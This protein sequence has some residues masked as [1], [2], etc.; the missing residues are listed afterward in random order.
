MASKKYYHPHKKFLPTPLEDLLLG[1]LRRIGG[2]AVLFVSGVLWLSLLTWSATDPSL[3]VISSQPPSNA[4]GPLGA[5]LADLLLNTI[6]LSAV[7]VL[8]CC[9][10]WGLQLLLSERVEGFQVRVFFAAVAL[11]GIAGGSSALPT[12][13]GWLFHHGYGGIIGDVILNLFVGLLA[14]FQVSFANTLSGLSLFAFGFWAFSRAIG[15]DRKHIFLIIRPQ[16]RPRNV[17]Q[18]EPVHAEEPSWTKS[19]FGAATSAMWASQGSAASET[20]AQ[21]ATVAED[22]EPPSLSPIAQPKAE[23]N[24][25]RQPAPVRQEDDSIMGLKS[26]LEA[27]VEEA[28]VDHDAKRIAQIFA[29]E[30]SEQVKQPVQPELPLQQAPQPSPR[31]DRDLPSFLLNEREDEVEFFVEEEIALAEDYQQPS[32]EELNEPEPVSVEP[33]NAV[34]E[35]RAT[36]AKLKRVLADFRITGDIAD[37]KKGPMITLFEFVPSAGIKASRVVALADDIARSMS[38]ASARIS[39]MPGRNALA[40]ELPNEQRDT[41]ALKTLF[42]SAA[43]Q[44]TDARLPLMLGVDIVGEPIVTDLSRMPHLLVAGTTGSGKSVGINAMILSLLYR[45]TPQDCKFLMID[46]KMLEL[47]AYN[48]IPHMLAPVVTDPSEAVEALRWAVGEMEE[49]YKRMADLGVRNID[50]YNKRV[51]AARNGEAFDVQTG[52]DPV[53]RSATFETRFVNLEP[54]P[55]IVIVVDEFADLMSV[56]GKEVEAAMQRLAQMARAAGMH[57]IM[58]TQRPS[59]DVITGT[60]KAN[61]PARLAYRVASKIDSRTILQEQ[62][63]EQLLGQGDMLLSLAGQSLLRI[64]GP[65][66][67]EEEIEA[68]T[69]SLRSEV[70]P[71][72]GRVAQAA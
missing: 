43:F 15:L 23:A 46:P 21:R 28:S 50:S 6:G 12:A 53:S 32:L 39:A 13:E 8:V 63:A 62:G 26:R 60:L 14:Q 20:A 48:G 49:R 2:A 67:T 18:D 37:V 41:I 10:V 27:S 9:F 65:M 54:M 66:V 35:H 52:F 29:P 11:V 72:F 68:V 51:A 61:F 40:I 16:S 70:G 3:S 22:A 55:N 47:S 7:F 25:K 58:A 4:L 69:R 34:L 44:S 71:K 19:A 45:K 57:L 31:R 5:A 33:Q 64:H 24:A 30:N 59:V 56:A 1:W 36:A 42:N 17:K 38:A